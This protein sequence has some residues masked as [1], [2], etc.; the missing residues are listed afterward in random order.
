MPRLD[1]QMRRRIILLNL[2]S[3]S[4]SAI[5]K[6]LE[7]ESICVSIQAM[8]DLL[9]KYSRFKTYLDLPRRKME[10]KI[11]PEM[12]IEMDTE[13]HHNDELTARQLQGIL[14]GKHP[15]VNVSLP[16]IKRAR[17]LMGW[18]CTR[19]HYCQLIREVCTIYLM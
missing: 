5:K 18:V 19:P 16:T 8:Y 9:R 4:V 3:Y 11:T 1:L 17:K 2:Y 14:K 7:E 12:L 15:T 6:R 13:L 10:R